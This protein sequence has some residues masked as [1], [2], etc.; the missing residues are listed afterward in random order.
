V[1]AQWLATHPGWPAHGAIRRRAEAQAA[2]SLIRIG[3]Q[4]IRTLRTAGQIGINLLSPT[5]LYDVTTADLLTDLDKLARRLSVPY[6]HISQAIENR[7][8]D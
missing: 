7:R 5:D 3:D 4:G 8:D 2:E 6:R 1:Q